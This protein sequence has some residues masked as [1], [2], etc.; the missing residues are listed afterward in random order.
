MEIVDFIFINICFIW[1]K[2]ED[3]VCKWLWVFD[4][5]KNNCFGILVGVFGC[6]VEWLKIKLL[7]EEKLVD[8]VI[9]LDV[10]CDLFKLIVIVEDGDK[11]INVFFFCE[12]I[13]VDINFMC[14]DSNG[15]M[16]FIFIMWGCDNMCFFCV[17]FFICG[18]EWSCNVFS[19]V[20]EVI[21]L[22]EW[23]YWEVIL[24]G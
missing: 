7:D 19:I 18:W 3:I 5:V 1:E 9:G 8:F 15:V 10:Y 20:V 16:V 24:L 23:G 22:Y 2:V 17:V 12:E 21:D 14:F 11:G 13:Y 4:K 6:M